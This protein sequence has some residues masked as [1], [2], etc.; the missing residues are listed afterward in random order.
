MLEGAGRTTLTASMLA[1]ARH[2]TG[3]KLLRGA[4]HDG[5]GPEHLE[6]MDVA[7]EVVRPGVEGTH[8][9]AFLDRPRLRCEGSERRS[10]VGGILVEDVDIVGARRARILV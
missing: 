1:R 10:S 7:L 6:R 5:E 9:E 3:R 4:L 8:R 2:V